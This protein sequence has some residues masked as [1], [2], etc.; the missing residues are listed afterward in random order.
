MIH[1]QILHKSPKLDMI[2]LGFASL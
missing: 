2:R 1:N